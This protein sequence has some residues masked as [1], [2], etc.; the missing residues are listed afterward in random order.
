ML[1]KKIQEQPRPIIPQEADASHGG[2]RWPTG[3]LL[4]TLALTVCILFA[5]T[6]LIRLPDSVIHLHLGVGSFL[7]TASSWLPSSIGPW[8][9]ATSAIIELFTLI[10]LTFLFYGLGALSVRSQSTKGTQRAV[11]WTGAFL[12]GAILSITPAM[13]SHDILVYASY[14]RVLAAYHANPYFVPIAAFP[15]D[16]FTPINY[17]ANSVSAYGPIWMLVCACFGQILSPAPVAYVLAFRLLALASHLCNTWLVGQTLHIMGRTPR[18]VTL[19][20]LLYAWNPLLLLEASLGGHND[21]FMITFVLAGILLAARAEKRAETLRPHGYL[22]VIGALTLA[23]LVKYTSL[24]LLAVYLLFL[25]CK[26]IRSANGNTQTISQTLSNWR[27]ILLTI[28]SSGLCAALLALTFYGPFWLG[29]SPQSIIS[30]FKNPPS[31]L[32]SQNSFMR[33]VLEWEKLHPVRAKSSLFQLLSSRR[34]WDDLTLAAIILCLIAAGKLLWS[35]T[36][37]HNVILASLL[38]MSAVLLITP[39]FY[40]WYITWLLGLAALCLP[41][42]QNRLTTALFALTLTFSFS[43]LLTYLFREDPFTSYAYLISLFTTIPP[44]CAFLLTLVWWNFTE[45]S[46]TGERKE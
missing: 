19:G 39:W 41:A 11:I 7:A 17:W 14:S 21:S 29:H 44:A 2:R 12:A 8:P 32:Y 35:R 13:L 43:A 42:R 31:A 26:A 10:L 3:L 20:I 23:A 9:Q 1:E 4:C 40:S 25:A 36:T 30:S 46:T 22:P 27:P 24:P 37:I 5:M 45:K 28:G 16:P 15:H 33:S 6:P 38:T 34:L 18:T